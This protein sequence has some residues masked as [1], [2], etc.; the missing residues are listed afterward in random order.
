MST[1]LDRFKD[2][3]KKL[4]ALGHEM[5]LDLTFRSMEE[6]NRLEAKYEE[7]AKKIKGS[8]EK[9]YQRWHTDSYAVIKQILA[10]R[11]N[12]FVDLYRPDAKRK[13]VDGV[14]YRIQDWLTGSRSAKNH[15]GQQYFNDFAITSMQF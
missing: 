11:L 15:Y 14:T 13:Q 10:D 9:N 7:T 8:F 3:L 1:N 6:G 4:I 12:E 2:D 5:N